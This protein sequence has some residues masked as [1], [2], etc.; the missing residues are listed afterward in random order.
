LAPKDCAYRE[1]KP[2]DALCYTLPVGEDPAQR[3]SY[4]IS[5]TAQPGYD[6]WKFHDPQNRQLALRY[7]FEV[8][9]AAAEKYFAGNCKVHRG[10]DRAVSIAIKRT[11]HGNQEIWLEPY[12]LAAKGE[13]G[14]LIDF[15]FWKKP[16]A[17][18]FREVQRLSLGLDEHYRSNRNAY[19]DREKIIANFISGPLASFLPIHHPHASM[20][21]NVNRRL[22]AVDVEQLKPKVFVLADNKIDESQWKG[23]ERHGPLDEV[24]DKPVGCIM[25]FQKEHRPL[26]ED[27]YRGLMGKTSGVAFKG[28]P[29][30][31]GLNFDKYFSVVPQRWTLPELEA[32]IAQIAQIKRDNPGMNLIVVMVEDI[33][34]SEI[35]FEAKYRLLS[36]G[37]PLQVISV[38]LIQRRDQ[39]KWSVSNIALQI[40]TKLGGIPWKVKPA[41]DNCLVIGIGQAHRLGVAGIQRYFAYCVATDSSGLYKK[42]AVL[43]HT[44]SRTTYIA[45]LQ[46]SLVREMLA[47]DSSCYTHCV[48]HVPFKLKND[49]LEALEEA[50]QSAS[51][52]T[53]SVKFA[54]L[55]INDDHRFFGYAANNSRVPIE[56]TIA[57]LGATS[58]LLWFE[59]L[60]SS[61]DVVSK[62][63]AGPVHLEFLWPKTEPDHQEQNRYLQDLFN[64]S[65]TNWRGF[66]AR[67][68]PIST[69]YCRL[70]AKFLAA[71][72]E[73]LPRI[74]AT[75]H[76]WFL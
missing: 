30:V 15:H 21:L 29:T 44:N 5:L 35:Y 31:F 47:T 8:L 39:F 14:F 54:V 40:F 32:S 62:R 22:T 4:L 60:K 24:H 23:L 19:I 43:S 74:E 37:V 11:P 72:P 57:R 58:M 9:A 6:A 42:I 69:Y 16:D 26:A 17:T 10:F 73:Q 52:A 28:M 68:T 18:S 25:L 1:T 36:L 59:G 51:S 20:P 45:D 63:I 56:G 46:H 66:N 3:G 49:E 41:Y 70:I 65:G 38:Q 76:P 12:F 71:F 53:A 7:I 55:K 75:G 48:L 67:S 64:L 33:E 27:L 50:V 34:N 13:F 2:R 61:S